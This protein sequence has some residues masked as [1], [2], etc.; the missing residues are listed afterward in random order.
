L[1]QIEKIKKQN[2]T[3]D[4]LLR[5][6]QEVSSVLRQPMH[7]LLKLSLM[8][9]D[10]KIFNPLNDKLISRDS[11]SQLQEYQCGTFEDNFPKVISDASILHCPTLSKVTFVF[12]KMQTAVAEVLIRFFRD[13]KT[14]KYRNNCNITKIR[15]E[16]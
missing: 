6:N 2:K 10:F 5:W 16:Y 11:F 15:F 1:P 4:D 9:A 7:T 13:A 3:I 12:S 8:C 14:M